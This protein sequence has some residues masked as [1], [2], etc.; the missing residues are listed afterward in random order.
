MTL[1]TN[2]KYNVFLGHESS[3]DRP[4]RPHW[5]LKH[6]LERS[7]SKIKE[8]NPN[9][10]CLQRIRRQRAV[11]EIQPLGELQIHSF[12]MIRMLDTYPCAGH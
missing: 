8:R 6:G 11:W 12:P 7:D 2:A 9:T 4:I 1:S 10:L 5:A 3:L